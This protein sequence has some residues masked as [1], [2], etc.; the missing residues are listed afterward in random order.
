M[1]MDDVMGG[2]GWTGPGRDNENVS[3]ANFLID[4]KDYTLN[5]NSRKILDGFP[6]HKQLEETY[7]SP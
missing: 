3:M 4:D 6:F 7:W 5:E 2:W 1:G